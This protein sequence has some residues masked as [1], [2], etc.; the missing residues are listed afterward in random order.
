M[1]QFSKVILM[2]ASMVFAVSAT[3]QAAAESKEPQWESCGWGGGGFYWAAAFH[4]T[5]DGVIYLGSDVNGVYRSDDHGRNFRII[6]N[7]LADYGVFSLAV[8][9]SSPDTIY[10]A[11]TG[12]LCKS[13]DEGEHW[14]LL[15][16]T[17]PN[18][19]RIT[20]EKDRSIRC[21]AVN[22]V[23]SNVVYAG[24]P[25]GKIFKSVDGGEIWKVVY[26]NLSG[27]AKPGTLRVQFGKVNDQY[28]GGMWFALKAPENVKP[29]D[30]TGIG[31][32]FKGDGTKQER[33]FI[34]LT[35]G[36]GVSYR[37]K[38]LNEVFINS[39]WHDIVLKA[40][41]FE[42]DP[43]YAAKHKDETA[44]LPA[45]PNWSAVNRIDFSCNGAMPTHASVGQFERFFFATG[46]AEK[47]VLVSARDFVGD[48]TVQTYG[49]IG[50]G[51]AQAG[52]TVYSVAVS[53]QNPSLVVAATSDCGL[54]LSQDAGQTWKELKTP[55]NASSATFAPNDSQVVYGTFFGDGIWKSTDT[56]NSWS[57]LTNGID[58]KVNA[59]EVAVSHADPL[60]VYAIGHAEWA[61]YLWRSTDAGATWKRNTTVAVDV[62]GDPTLPKEGAMQGLSYTSNIT[63]SLTNPKE[64]YIS[65]NW[66]SVLSEDGGVTLTER[67]RGADISCVN[68]IR[69][70]GKQA[71]AVAMDEGL[72]VSGDNGK[73]W[74]QLWPLKYATELSGHCWRVAINNVNGSDH[75]VS[76]FNPW[77]NSPKMSVAVVSDDQGK[78]YQIVKSGLPDYEPKLNT[79]WGEGYMRALAADPANPTVLYAGIDGDPEPGKMGGGIFKS[80]DGGYHWKQLAHQPG[81]RR[82]FYGLAVDQTDS[83]RIF[84]GCCGNNGGVWRTEDGGDTWENVFANETW[85]WNVL[86][87]KEGMVYAVGANLWKSSDHGKTWTQVSK[88]N[89]GRVI[90]GL[91]VD[92]RNSKTLWISATTWDGSSNGGIYKT[93]DDGAT[94]Q[95]L[96]GNIPN[97]KPMTLRFNPAANELWAAGAGMYKIKQ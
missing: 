34:M 3:A 43:D 83:K 66:R 64:L 59:L 40:E 62:D 51:N 12:G 25:A 9:R 70:S 86:T 36:A 72:F 78:T 48:P 23:D 35:V 91:E 69:F 93:A 90:V 10:A 8:D 54:L 60:T 42:I 6:N 87:T 95:E 88:F 2:F 1:T 37:S 80:E 16:H 79:M 77:V 84:W 15:P 57:A 41:D 32:A 49:N 19:L 82:M 20:G 30:F 39:E 61:G 94:W 7:G 81:S 4:P 13:S 31:F 63:V 26:E 71:Y 38:N 56:G 24:S 55:K 74:R 46:S 92:P 75:I 5:K 22:P 58:Q 28:F 52:G 53:E 44:K 29:E 76:T 47:Q 14:K 89:N 11:T 85:I 45:S 18:D 97:V 33:T 17:G 50:L 65:A 96:T 73:Q 68:D 67:N 27:K 21:V